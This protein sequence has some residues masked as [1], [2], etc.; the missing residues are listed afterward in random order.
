[1]H[2]PTDRIAHTTAFVT[3]VVEHWLER[4]IAQWVHPMK[5]RSNDPSHH[6]RTLLPEEEEEEVAWRGSGGLKTCGRSVGG[7]IF[8]APPP[9]PPPPSLM[10]ARTDHDSLRS[11]PSSQLPGTSLHATLRLKQL[12]EY[13]ALKKTRRLR[14][15]CCC[16]FD[17]SNT[18]KRCIYRKFVYC[19]V[20]LNSVLF[21]FFS[22]YEPSRH[23]SP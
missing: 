22:R 23:S 3:P 17:L 15:H 2:N 10:Q 7:W 16:S 19:I 20:S 8:F 13:V 6:E 1:M 18:S 12:V 5:D 4:V 14:H 21:F 11:S 9:P